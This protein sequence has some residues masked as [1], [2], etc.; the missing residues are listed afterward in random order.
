M[1]SKNTIRVAARVTLDIV[2]PA[3]PPRRHAPAHGGARRVV[4]RFP[5][6]WADDD[7][8]SHNVSLRACGAGSGQLVR[9]LHDGDERILKLASVTRLPSQCCILGDEAP[10]ALRRVPA[11]RRVGIE[12]PSDADALGRYTRSSIVHPCAARASRRAIS[13]RMGDACDGTTAMLEH[14]AV[15]STSE[16]THKHCRCRTWDL[17][18]CHLRVSILVLCK[19]T[20]VWLTRMKEP[21]GMV[22]PL[23]NNAAHG[24][25]HHHAARRRGCRRAEG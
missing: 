15:T 8:A 3:A 25:S 24:T 11:E 6:G 2:R 9:H 1:I 7:L 10:N 12:G 13:L 18:R 21:G 14:A 17:E 16:H 22:L 5:P 20:R 23:M 4:C 19:C